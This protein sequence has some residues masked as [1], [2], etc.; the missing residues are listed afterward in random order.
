MGRIRDWTQ[1]LGTGR[2]CTRSRTYHGFSLETPWSP[3]TY[4]IHGLQC[5]SFLNT[6]I[7]S[8]RTSLPLRGGG[9]KGTLILAFFTDGI[10]LPHDS[11]HILSMQHPI[12]PTTLSVKQPTPCPS[13]PWWFVRLRNGNSETYSKYLWTL[14]HYLP[15]SLLSPLL[16]YHHYH[17]LHCS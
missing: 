4:Q 6:I 7:S 13:L 16:C 1:L 9:C 2:Q 15:L 8:A 5:H 14:F 12:R 17:P 10:S 11:G 3:S